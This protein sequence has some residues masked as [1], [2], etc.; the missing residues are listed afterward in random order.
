MS[1]P[2]IFGTVEYQGAIADLVITSLKIDH[3]GS[4]AELMDESGS[5]FQVNAYGAKRTLTIDGCVRGS[6]DPVQLGSTLT[7][8]GVPYLVTSVSKTKTNQGH[9]TVSI[10]AEAPLAIAGSTVSMDGG[11]ITV[12]GGTSS[13]QEG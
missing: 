11:T 5:I 12:S 3:A 1:N 8:D 7:I 6:A 4:V 9:H 13:N 10:S 2:V